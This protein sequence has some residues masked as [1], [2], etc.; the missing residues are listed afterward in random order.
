MAWKPV[1]AVASQHVGHCD[2]C[3]WLRKTQ[4]LEECVWDYIYLE[5]SASSHTFWLL[6]WLSGKESACN[7]GDVDLILGL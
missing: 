2:T 1:G 7:A 6:Q 3:R 5:F 4:E